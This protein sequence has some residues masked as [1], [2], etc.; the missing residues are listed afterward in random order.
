MFHTLSYWFSLSLLFLVSGMDESQLQLASFL[1]MLINLHK[2]LVSMHGLLKAYCACL[3]WRMIISRVL[4][5]ISNL[6]SL[7]NLKRWWRHDHLDVASRLNPTFI[8]GISYWRHST[9]LFMICCTNHQALDGTRIGCV[10]P[11]SKMYG[12]SG[13]RYTNKK[14]FCNYKLC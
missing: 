14:L 6:D 5:I 4:V 9:M 11:V 12:I 2:T 13:S 10:W 3:N 8:Q 7:R 1:L